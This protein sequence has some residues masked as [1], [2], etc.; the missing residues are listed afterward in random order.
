M[1]MMEQKKK[2]EKMKRPKMM[3]LLQKLCGEEQRT[4]AIILTQRKFLHVYDVR[5]IIRART[6]NPMHRHIWHRDRFY[7]ICDRA[8]ARAHPHELLFIRPVVVRKAIWSWAQMRRK[9]IKRRK[10][11]PE[12]NEMW[13]AIKRWSL[14]PCCHWSSHW[15]N[16]L[17]PSFEMIGNYIFASW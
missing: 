10:S 1:M 7:R 5:R 15:A 4:L 11:T 13:W 9:R 3:L 14:A 8:I 17:C 2:M 16:D 6:T 12:A